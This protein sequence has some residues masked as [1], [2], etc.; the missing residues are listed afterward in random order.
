MQRTNQSFFWDKK[1]DDLESMS[2]SN[3]SGMSDNV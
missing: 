3:L 1:E 2:L